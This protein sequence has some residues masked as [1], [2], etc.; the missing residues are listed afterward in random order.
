MPNYV[1]AD[2]CIDEMRAVVRRSAG[3][4][5][6]ERGKAEARLCQ[7]LKLRLKQA[8]K[9]DGL[10]LEL[11]EGTELSIFR[12]DTPAQATTTRRIEMPRNPDH[13]YVQVDGSQYTFETVLGDGGDVR[14]VAVVKRAVPRVQFPVGTTVLPAHQTFGY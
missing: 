7:P 9:D 12:H 5:V 8:P 10:W 14:G 11:D 6:L 2:E 13:F 3:E 1:L 4:A